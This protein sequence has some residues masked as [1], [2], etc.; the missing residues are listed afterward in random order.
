MQYCRAHAGTGAQ[1][2]CLQFLSRHCVSLLKTG[3]A[4]QKNGKSALCKPV[5][6]PEQPPHPP[7]CNSGSWPL[8][9]SLNTSVRASNYSMVKGL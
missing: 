6:H 3:Q 2:V 8:T 9:T 5:Q 1:V 4:A 7:A